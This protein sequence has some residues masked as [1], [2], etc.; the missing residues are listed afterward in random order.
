MKK[1][2]GCKRK[3]IQYATLSILLFITQSRAFKGLILYELD[4]KQIQASISEGVQWYRVS[5][6]QLSAIV[7]LRYHVTG[8]C[9]KQY[10]D[11]TQKPSLAA[12]ISIHSN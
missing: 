8:V 4:I 9:V 12:L 7:T 6:K 5:K 11:F 1:H 2:I 10:E 3:L